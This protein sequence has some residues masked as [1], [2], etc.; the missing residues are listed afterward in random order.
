MDNLNKTSNEYGM[1]IHRKKTKV[2]RI[3][4]KEAS[5]QYNNQN[6]WSKTGTSETV[7][8]SGKHDNRRLQKPQ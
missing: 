6:R 8:L 3:S 2:M 1:K 5:K 7:Q 4:R